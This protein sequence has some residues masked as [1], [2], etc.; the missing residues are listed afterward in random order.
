MTPVTIVEQ[1]Q[2]VR[3]IRNACRHYMTRDQ[4]TIS[5][6]QQETWFAILPDNVQLYLL[7]DVGYGLVR[8]DESGSWLSGGLLPEARGRGLGEALFRG[9]IEASPARPAL[10]VL[11]GNA[12]AFNLYRKLG[13]VVNDVFEREVL[14]DDDAAGGGPVTII[15][16]R[17]K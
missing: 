15:E 10:E 7:D 11:R 4:R 9:L 3:E 13:F 2:R 6:E 5:A 12:P 8:T 17:L 16:M 14:R 1:A